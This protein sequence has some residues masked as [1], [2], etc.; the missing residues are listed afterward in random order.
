MA[1]L[2]TVF[3]LF[4]SYDYLSLNF[5]PSTFQGFW[6]LMRRNFLIVCAF[7]PCLLSFYMMR[8]VAREYLDRREEVG[9]T[10]IEFKEIQNTESARKEGLDTS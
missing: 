7:T 3:Q 10:E 9:D 8:E 4:I 5:K 6:Q 2:V 1:L